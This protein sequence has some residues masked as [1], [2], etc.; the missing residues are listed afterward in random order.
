MSPGPLTIPKKITIL[1]WSVNK[2]IDTK[3]DN[4]TEEKSTLLINKKE[5]VDTKRST[6]NAKDKTSKGS[7]QRRSLKITR[8]SYKDITGILTAK[9]QNKKQNSMNFFCTELKNKN[10]KSRSSLVEEIHDYKNNRTKTNNCNQTTDQISRD[11]KDFVQTLYFNQSNEQRD[12]LKSES[13]IPKYKET[14][15]R[16]QIVQRKSFAIDSSKCNHLFAIQNIKHGSLILNKH[17]SEKEFPEQKDNLSINRSMVSNTRK[18]KP[19]L[20]KPERISF[21]KINGPTNV[22]SPI[23]KRKKSKLKSD[24]LNTLR[25]T[26]SLET[27]MKSHFIFEMEKQECDVNLYQIPLEIKTKIE[28]QFAPFQPNVFNPKT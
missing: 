14:D 4:T 24:R 7:K 12:M 3:L 20:P 28:S 1:S 17:M 27:K 2:N 26:R 9:K 22:L 6:V 25:I 13:N 15:N 16:E 5:Y 19:I 21:S 8:Y 23:K 11:E 10:V 18:T